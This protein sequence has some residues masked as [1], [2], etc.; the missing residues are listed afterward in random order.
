MIE[1]GLVGREM[2]AG[3]TPELARRLEVLL[4]EAGR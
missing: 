1:V 2:L 3:L 4:S